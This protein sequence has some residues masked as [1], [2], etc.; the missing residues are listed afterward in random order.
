MAE[1]DE[2]VDSQTRCMPPRS[3]EATATIGTPSSTPSSASSAARWAA[4]STIASTFCRT[5][6]SAAER[7]LGASVS[8]MLAVITE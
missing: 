4:M 1:G 6:S 8:S 2:V 7:M 3:S 5:S